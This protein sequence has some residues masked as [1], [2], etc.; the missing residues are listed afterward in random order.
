MKHARLLEYARLASYNG[1]VQAAHYVLR[2]YADRQAWTDET[3]RARWDGASALLVWWGELAETARPPLD[4][5]SQ[6]D[7]LAF[8]DCL[9]ERGL[10]KTT[11]R[12]YR[13]GASAL[14]KALRGARTLPA[15]FDVQYAPFKSVHPVRTSHRTLLVNTHRLHNLPPAARARLELLL[16]L[17]A[18]GMSVPEVCACAWH[19]IDTNKRFLLG[20]HKRY[21]T[22]GVP[23]VKA[24]TQLLE[25]RPRKGDY[26]ERLLGWNADTARFWLKRIERPPLA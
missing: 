23:A 16:A 21:V 1:H 26:A 25:I 17:L 5:L 8:L 13:S 24:L 18:L 10:A 12:G 6:R 3:F 20:Y 19:D 7:A 22:L 4:N 11:I 14:T 15:S 2:W 9:A